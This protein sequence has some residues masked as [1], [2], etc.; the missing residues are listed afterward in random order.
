MKAILGPEFNRLSGSDGRIGGFVFTWALGMQVL[1]LHVMP[2]Q[3]QSADQVLIRSYLTAAAQAFGSLTAAERAQWETYANLN[4]KSHMGLPYTLYAI[5]AYIQVNSY[6]QINGQAIS[7]VA[8]TSLAGF[9]ASV[10]ATLGY[11]VGTTTY[12]FDVT[13]NGVAT[14]GFWVVYQTPVLASAQRA[15]RPSDYRL[16]DSV[17][18]DSIVAVAASPQTISITTPKYVP[19]DTDWQ[20]VRVVPLNDEYAPGTPTTFRGQVTVT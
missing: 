11:V 10:I 12:S 5:N 2:A 1:R 7:D 14:E 20:A 4:V 8:P 16:I 15:A 19:T 17:S 6:R 18:A 13:H 3:P 9:S